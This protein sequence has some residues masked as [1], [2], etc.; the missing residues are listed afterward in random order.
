MG[1]AHSIRE[2]FKEASPQL[3]RRWYVET[4]VL[5]TANKLLLTAINP[6][7]R[8]YVENLYDTDTWMTVEHA[9]IGSRLLFAMD[10][11]KVLRDPDLLDP[12]H[13]GNE[14]E[15]AVTMMRVFSLWESIRYDPEGENWYTAINPGQWKRHGKGGPSNNAIE[16][17]LNKFLTKMDPGT[18]QDLYRD[19]PIKTEGMGMDEIAARAAAVPARFKKFK[20]SSL[21]RTKLRQIL[22]RSS[23]MHLD[24][25]T[26][27]QIKTIA[28]FA[29]GALALVDS[30]YIDTLN[31][32][33]RIK[34]GEL[35]PLDI[36]Y[37]VTNANPI[38]WNDP[39]KRIPKAASD[40]LTRQ[41]D[42]L[43]L[44]EL[45]DEL[46]LAHCPTFWS[47]LT[48]A[49]PDPDERSAFLRLYGAAMYGT[50]I[51]IV[52]ALIGEPN[53]GKD[54]VLN[55]LNFVMPGQVAT[56]PF[57]A[58]TP[59]GDD[60]RGFAPLRGARVATVS[61]EVGEGRG[62]KLLAEKIKTV[63]SGGG[64]IRVAEK[65]EK[66]TDIWFD[67]MLL[68]QGNSVPQIA[69]G[70]RALYS[71]RLVAVEFKHPFPLVSRSYE[72]AYRSEAPW[73]AQV[74]F[75]NYLQYQ[76]EGGGMAG[77][78]PPEAWRGFA[79]EF[80][81]ASNPHGFLEACIVKSDKAI[82][83]S[84]FH[85]A[86]SAM[87]A[88]FGSPYPLGANYWPKR[89][90]TLGWPTKGPNTIRKQVAKNGKPV[91]SY[92]LTL[93]AEQSDGMFTQDQWDRILQE[94]AVTL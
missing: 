67:G 25:S 77:I 61:G 50:N 33:H 66:P 88:K 57:S 5:D 18:A 56:L 39:Q 92:Y 21:N 80:A 64:K 87:I 84:Q 93:D 1:L 42:Y 82:P 28:P 46:M 35:L 4:F 62:S 47:F 51:K 24:P 83:T 34:V 23:I 79:K 17:R 30:E 54:T 26:L 48:H 86:L 71:N 37:M 89:L 75:L 8:S 11:S 2:A 85:A 91:W 41:G 81:D 7:A 55:W 65:Y 68:L 36:E 43:Y 59:Y 63:S 58:F 10:P 14:D 45:Q 6:N 76:Q 19:W 69:G 12:E 78:N 38:P 44:E 74:L 52:A 73:F 20:G 60:D 90:R 15:I 9:A 49:F 29:N 27:N 32:T 3:L 70:D 31:I 53:A 13:W 16:E 72:A 22:E 40:P 94:S